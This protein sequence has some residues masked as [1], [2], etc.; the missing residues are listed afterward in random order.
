MA[1]LAGGSPIPEVERFFEQVQAGLEAAGLTATRLTG[2]TEVAEVLARFGLAVSA[3]GSTAWEL[4]ALGLPAL[5]VPVAANQAPVAAHLAD[6]GAALAWPELD[7][8]D[9][10][11][12][13]V[14][15]VVAAARALADD[16]RARHQLATRARR[17][18]DGL[19]AVRVATRM[20]ADTLGVRGASMADAELLLAWANDPVTRAQ[21]FSNAPIDWDTHLAWLTARLADPTAGVY[22]VEGPSGPVGQVRLAPVV[23]AEAVG[24]GA[25]VEIGVVVAPEHRGR[26]L[27]AA[28]IDAGLRFGAGRLAARR[29]RARIKVDNLASQRSFV[30]AD[31][32]RDADQPGRAQGWLGYTRHL[33]EPEP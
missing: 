15:E 1:L 21:S 20:R 10:G 28:V 9:A 13:P 4:C 5:L 27:G 2:V 6:A 31:F 29:V 8:A 32:D 19:G 11:A 3:A 14:A 23:E 17:V 18:V 33:H 22:V 16:D 7:L 30:A 25:Q 26:H 12:G 24:D